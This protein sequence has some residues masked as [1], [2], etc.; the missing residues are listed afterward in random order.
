[1]ERDVICADTDPEAQEAIDPAYHSEYE[2]YEPEIV[3][4]VIGNDGH[5]VTI[6]LKPR[7]ECLVDDVGLE[8]PRRREKSSVIY[9]RKVERSMASR[10]MAASNGGSRSQPGTPHTS[11][12]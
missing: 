2:R 6:R 9:S 12:L 8:R 7:T 10:C 11:T 4:S 3:A 5:A 1:M